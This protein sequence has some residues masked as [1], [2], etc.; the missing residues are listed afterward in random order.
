MVKRI[1]QYLNESIWQLT[2]EQHVIIPAYNLFI[3][4]SLYVPRLI[5]YLVQFQQF[6]LQGVASHS[7]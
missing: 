2:S 4:L 3:K 7:Q 6:V 1:P 5:N